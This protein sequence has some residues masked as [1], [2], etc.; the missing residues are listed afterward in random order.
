MTSFVLIEDPVFEKYIEVKC[1]VISM[2]YPR[3]ELC[4][5]YVENVD[6]NKTKFFTKNIYTKNHSEDIIENIFDEFNY[7]TG[8]E[9]LYDDFINFKFYYPKFN[10][11]LDYVS[12]MID[13][14]L[15]FQYYDCVYKIIKN[16]K[17]KISDIFRVKKYEEIDNVEYKYV[18][19]CQ[20]IL[21]DIEK[22]QNNPVEV[23][24]Y[25]KD[26]IK[27]YSFNDIVILNDSLS[28]TRDFK[29]VNYFDNNLN[30][31]YIIKNKLHKSL[32]SRFI[33]Q[34]DC[35][36][37]SKDCIGRY[38]SESEFEYLGHTRNFQIN[39]D[40]RYKGMYY[41]PNHCL[42]YQE[43]ERDDIIDKYFKF[44]NNFQIIKNKY[45]GIFYSEIDKNDGLKFCQKPTSKHIINYE[46][47]Y[48]YIIE[49]IV[50][51]FDNIIKTGNK[52]RLHLNK[53]GVV[54]VYDPN[55]DSGLDTI[56]STGWDDYV[57]ESNYSKGESDLNPS[58]IENE[59]YLDYLDEGLHRYKMYSNKW[60]RKII[61]PRYFYPLCKPKIYLNDEFF[62]KNICPNNIKHKI[63]F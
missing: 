31:N 54:E 28:A 52:I 48:I 53:S 40:Y 22:K 47:N 57:V 33:L 55:T 17:L 5:Y 37:I 14:Y 61:L 49:L 60:F 13:G 32:E 29:Y 24:F 56:D 58:L 63:D 25:S 7:N 59:G 18:I 16:I 45:S 11:F 15:L 12:H 46:E 27:Y 62:V 4:I 34:G 21:T 10:I 38:K 19:L 9:F 51:Y 39:T 26:G 41:E 35:T 44:D 3:Q 43:D 6:I 36:R 8:E 42:I 30:L 1:N 50:I 20:T 2:Y 23:N